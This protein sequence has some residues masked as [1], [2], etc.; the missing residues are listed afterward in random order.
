MYKTFANDELFA[1][2]EEAR[3][4]SMRSQL[5]EKV[6][7]TP[8]QRDSIISMIALL[9]REYAWE[10]EN[11]NIDKRIVNLVSDMGF[12]IAD[13]DHTAK[14][15]KFQR[16]L[17]QTDKHLIVVQY[18]VRKRLIIPPEW[19]QDPSALKKLQA[20]SFGSFLKET[21][22]MPPNMMGKEYDEGEMLREEIEARKDPIQAKLDDEEDQTVFEISLI[23]TRNQALTVDCFVKNGEINMK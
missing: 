9:E 6:R 3:R 8:K 18:E 11:Y 2:V 21:G 17:K 22:L 14:N 5:N 4:Q 10:K 15:E 16:L 12:V 1:R 7:S 23:N 19:Q 20:K 13:S